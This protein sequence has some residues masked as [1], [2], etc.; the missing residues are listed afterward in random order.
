MQ[1]DIIHVQGKYNVEDTE[2]KYAHI[3]GGGEYGNPKN[4]HTLDWEGNSEFAGDVKANACGSNSPVSLVEVSK[5]ASEAIPGSAKGV[6]NG[7]AQLDETGKVP[8]EQ[9]PDIGGG[10]SSESEIYQGAVDAGYIGTSY[11]F[12]QQL[13]ALLASG[14]SNISSYMA[15]VP[16]TDVIQGEVTINEPETIQ[17]VTNNE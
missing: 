14:G 6:A 17:E 7:V 8:V 4:I 16:H 10:G 1:R 13:Y 11:E 15:L 9:L 12:G 5:V 3:V 2:N